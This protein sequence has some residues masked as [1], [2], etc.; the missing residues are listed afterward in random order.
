MS[1]L[2]ASVIP[3]TQGLDLT[4]PKMLATPGTLIDCLNYE[5]VDEGGLARIAGY[6]RYSGNTDVSISKFY[7]ITSS[8]STSGFSPGD[9]IAS[10]DWESFLGGGSANT[11]K[12]ANALRKYVGVVLATGG[13]GGDN[14]LIFAPFDY[15]IDFATTELLS[16]GKLNLTT[17]AIASG[18]VAVDVVELDRQYLGNGPTYYNQ[19]VAYQNT[20]RGFVADLPTVAVGLHWFGDRLYAVAGA[21][22]LEFASAG[23]GVYSYPSPGTPITSSGGSTGLVLESRETDGAT[24]KVQL[25]IL[26]Y[27]TGGWVGQSVASV[28]YDPFGSPTLPLVQSVLG[29]PTI[30]HLWEAVPTLS[31][32]ENGTPPFNLGWQPIFHGWTVNFTDGNRLAGYFNKVEKN[33]SNA[34]PTLYYFSDGATTLSGY[35]NSYYIS[36]G[37]L[38]LGTGAGTFQLGALTQVAGTG[39]SLKNTYSVYADA[40]LTIL[41]AEISNN[42]QFTALPGLSF[43]VEQDSR[44]VFETANFYAVD[45]LE[46][47]YGVSGA[48]KAFYYNG[49]IFCSVYTGTP[50]DRPRHV[51][52][53]LGHLALGYP[54]GAVLLSVVGQ[55][56]N[57]SGLLGATE[58]AVGDRLTG[59]SVLQGTTLG[60]FCSQSV[61]SISGSTT[62]AFQTQI[63]VPNVGCIEYSLVDMGQPIFT[64]NWGITT[65]D[66]SAKYGDFEGNRLSKKINKDL[67]PRIIDSKR[68]SPLSSG[69]LCAFPVR[70]KNQYRLILKDGSVV[71]MTMLPDG[72]PAFT[73]QQYS[74][75]NGFTEKSL[76]PLAISSEVDNFGSERIHVSTW[77]ADQGSS[78]YVYEMETGWSFDGKYI[79]HNFTI[80][81][82]YG[83]N[84]TTFQTLQRLRLYGQ[85]HGYS[86][87][88]VQAAGVQNDMYFNGT[89]FSTTTTPINLPRSFTE[90]AAQLQDTTN[91]VNI[92]AR[93][94]A[95]QLKF[96]GSNTDLSVIEPSHTA[97]VLVTYSSPDGAFDL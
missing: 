72:P 81:W 86:S 27:E 87:L 52:N 11:P 14:Y 63:L 71:S 94:L 36:S 5:A 64:S 38:T 33:P 96:S 37:N 90:Y 34:A 17:G 89:S 18:S 3:L 80:N 40:G 21:I 12:S 67:L 22:M 78:P 4:T 2:R 46:A 88:K 60:V 76:R 65:L 75:Y 62:D 49:N 31:E 82:F 59:L 28:I 47:M 26:D 84:P 7:R 13:G 85:S 73:Y 24:P 30:A 93:G 23:V 56:W 42:M 45:E 61:W 92:A 51:A 54:Q 44:Y 55:P 53:H 74:W 68:G 70:A 69:V 9:I 15:S 8:S 91:S 6:D 58:L 79:P 83:E 41:V 43:I 10:D 35:I 48:G 57:F 77:D 32:L 39:R 95:V 97:Q 25:T 19:L 20:L 1:D 29:D 16:V 50:D 66:Q